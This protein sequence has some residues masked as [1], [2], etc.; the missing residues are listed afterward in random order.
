MKKNNLRMKGKRERKDKD[1]KPKL[2][3]FRIFSYLF[4]EAH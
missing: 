3:G 1:I 2:K 4:T